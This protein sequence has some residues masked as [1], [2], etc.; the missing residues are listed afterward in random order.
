MLGALEEPGQGRKLERGV[1]AM[2]THSITTSR[3]S[4][5]MLVRSSLAG[6]A[7]LP[8]ESLPDATAGAERTAGAPLP[9]RQAA[10]VSPAGWRTW[11]LATPDEL[12]PPA[13]G[14]PTADEIEAVLTLQEQRTDEATAVVT[15]WGAGLGLFP[16][17]KMAGELFTEFAIVGLP[18]GRFLAVY[19]TALHDAVIA[20]RDA[21]V[22]HGR[23]S[24]AATDDRIIPL[25]GVDPNRPSFPSEHA[26]IA[27]AA[28]VVLAYLL[29]D[30]APGRFDDLASEAANSRIAAGAAFP[31]DIE[32]G[33]AVGER[34]VARA[35]GDG[36]DAEWDPS[37]M[38]TGPG[39]WKPTPPG[40]VELPLRPLEGTRLPWIMASGD[41]FRP[42]PPPEYG[43]PAWQAEL[44]AVQEIAANRS[45]EQTR[46]ATWWGTSSP[47]LLFND[48]THELIARD[49]LDLPHA[50][51]ILAYLHVAVDDA[52]IA[53]FDA[54]YTWWTS[55]PITEDPGLVT[56]VPTPPYPAYPSG[57]SADVG[58]AS[59][60]VGHFFPHEADDFAGRAWEAAASRA[61]AGIHYVIDDDIGLTMGRQVGRL[62]TSV[63]GNDGAE[64][65]A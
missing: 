9:R 61:W 13:P 64:G 22:A 7:L 58:A 51:R 39:I 10:A 2:T 20:A 25:A 53:V 4:R 1:L 34:A 23:P 35:Q 40:F 55:R 49:G 19:H 42:G 36:A 3:L 15:K 45:F 30:A 62:A 46:A 8:L 6:A 44:E 14:A 29:P 28:A 50:A 18:E 16:W 63:A 5:R 21:Q 47:S 48:W 65:A 56:V 12:R 54:K 11:Y 27:G 60:V 43:S 31:S 57:Y 17:S 41:Q 32:V 38:R 52:L 26:A 24:P 37:T 59:T 33:R